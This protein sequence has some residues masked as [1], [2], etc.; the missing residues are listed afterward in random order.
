MYA[1]NCYQITKEGWAKMAYEKASSTNVFQ[2]TKHQSRETVLNL[3]TI[4]IV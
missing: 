3:D 4:T 1:F 2:A